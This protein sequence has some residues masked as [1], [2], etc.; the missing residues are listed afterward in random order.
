VPHVRRVFVF[1]SNLG[2]RE[3]QLGQ[4]NVVGDLA[5]ATAWQGITGAIFLSDAKS[6]IKSQL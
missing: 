3:S 2:W 4:N 5:L 1:A 6:G